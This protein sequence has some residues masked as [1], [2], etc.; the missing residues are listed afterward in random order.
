M[1]F[2]S[3]AQ[4]PA[5]YWRLAFKHS[6]PIALGYLPAGIAFGILMVAAGFPTWL[7]PL[8]SGIVYSGAMQYAAI[9]MLIPW[10]GL[11]SIGINTIVIGLRHVFYG[12]PLIAY[13]PKNKL[14]RAYCIFALTDETF[15]VMTTLPETLRRPLFVRIALLN[16][17]Y[18]FIGT[19]VGMWVGSGFGNLIPHLDF[20]LSCLF[21][22]LAYE[23]YRI[24]RQWLPCALAPVAF[25]C[26]RYMAPQYLLLVAVS[27]CA[28]VIV[29]VSLCRQEEC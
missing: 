9:G 27:L 20:A 1:S 15:S 23:Q 10:A 19:L 17:I 13:L 14:L 22:I 16:Q 8:S 21:V 5:N 28:L 25:V 18:W 12:L 3:L 24:H 2:D 11:L 6:Y 7:A 4:V 26:A 29:S